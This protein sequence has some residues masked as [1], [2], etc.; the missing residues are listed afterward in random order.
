MDIRIKDLLPNCEACKGTDGF[1]NLIL[2]QNQNSFVSR[3]VEA[4][5]IT[6]SRCN[7][8]G[9]IMTESRKAQLEF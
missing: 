6:C 2:K 3:L 4:S 9:V 1:E 8:D 5:A 7:G